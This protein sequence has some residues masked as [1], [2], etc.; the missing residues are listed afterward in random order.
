MPETESRRLKAAGKVSPPS[1][2]IQNWTNPEV[3]G[4]WELCDLD[5]GGTN[6][7]IP[8]GSQSSSYCNAQ[9]RLVEDPVRFD[10]STVNT[11][12][13]ST[14][15]NIKNNIKCFLSSKSAY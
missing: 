3:K 6:E 4:Q 1:S 10:L 7:S 9:R 12:K 15:F 11:T 8:T 14:V 5:D 2:F 13:N